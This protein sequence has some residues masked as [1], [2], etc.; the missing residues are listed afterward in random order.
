MTGSELIFL[1]WNDLVGLSCTRSVPVVEYGRRRTDGL[2]CGMAGQ[3]LTPF[4]D[5][6]ENPWGSMGEVRH[7]DLGKVARD[8]SHGKAFENLA[9]H[10]RGRRIGNVGNVGRVGQR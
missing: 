3:A 5:T 2:G 9:V 1:V 6:A 10:G 8:I 7:L 4:E